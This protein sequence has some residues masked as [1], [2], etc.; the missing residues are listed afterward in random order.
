[1]SE[2]E[3]QVKVTK[4]AL[5]AAK[6]A[7]AERDKI[8]EV[9]KKQRVEIRR[10]KRLL[11]EAVKLIPSDVRADKLFVEIDAALYAEET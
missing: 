3:E 2:I 10:F 9:A 11:G 7:K 8:N 5:N 4:R 6:T 1:M